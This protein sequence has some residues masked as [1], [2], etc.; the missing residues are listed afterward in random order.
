VIFRQQKGN[1]R[2]HPNIRWIFGFRLPRLSTTGSIL[3]EQF[4]APAKSNFG[5]AECEPDPEKDEDR[6]DERIT[7]SFH[8]RAPS[9]P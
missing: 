9:M 7:S 4:V 5:L 2:V 1:R 6:D 8:F 3:H